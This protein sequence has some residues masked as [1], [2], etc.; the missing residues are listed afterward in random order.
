MRSSLRLTAAGLA[1]GVLFATSACINV[2]AVNIGSKSS[3]ERQLIGELEPLSE[4]EVL[5][6]SVR[7]QGQVG[8]GS[9]DAM[10]GA[11]L[12]ARR[13]QLFNRDEI[14]EAKHQGCIGEGRDA[15]LV[16]RPCSLREREALARVERLVAEENADRAAIIDWAIAADSTLSPAER[17][18]LL[19]IYRR[20]LADKAAKGDVL[21]NDDGS[22]APR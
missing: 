4:E 8:A 3:L 12:T 22:W 6:A 17:P 16:L 15:E 20:L 19:K 9:L 7:A 18:Q 14:E 21:Q 10:Q 13:R 1:F 2:T 5:A 11:A